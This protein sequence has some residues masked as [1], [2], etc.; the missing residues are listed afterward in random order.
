VVSIGF[1]TS[2]DG[3]TFQKSIKNP[4]L[5]PDGDD[6]AAFSVGAPVIIRQDSI[7]VMFFNAI[8][9]AR[10][11]PG[12]FV[13]RAV[14]WDIT[15]P[16]IKDELPVLTTGTMGEWDAGYISPCIVVRLTDGSL[17]MYYYGGIDFST[18]VMNFIGTAISTDGIT[19][20]KYNDPATHD[21]PFKESDPVLLTG[22]QN[23]WD[24]IHVHEAFICMFPEGYWMYYTGTPEKRS[25]LI[26][27]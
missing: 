19:W 4:V 27:I 7:W 18:N 22:E 11:G 9:A 16:W 14:A 26:K 1:A 8:E 6:F 23:E 10:W 17:R 5:F 25:R 3:Y 12:A 24:G 15:G 21:F 13:G 2:T 20:I